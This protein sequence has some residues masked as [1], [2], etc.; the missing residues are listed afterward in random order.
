MNAIDKLLKIEWKEDDVNYI[1][2]GHN[3]WATHGVKN[4]TNAHP[5]L[6]NRHTFCIV[7]NGIIENYESLKRMLQQHQYT[8]YSQTD[9]EVIVNLLEFHSLQSSSTYEAIQKT[10]QML[11]GTYGLIIQ[12][13]HDPETLYCVRNGSPL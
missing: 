1:G 13:I 4:D 3:R 7:H 9:T 10:I 2:F 6:S 8:F 5:H 11:Q 12:N